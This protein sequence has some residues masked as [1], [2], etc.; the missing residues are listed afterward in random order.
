VLDVPLFEQQ[1]AVENRRAGCPSHRVVGQTVELEAAVGLLNAAR[2]DSHP[3]FA[4]AVEAGL[5]SIRLFVDVDELLGR[6][7]QIERRIRSQRIGGSLGC[8]GISGVRPDVFEVAVQ[9]R[10]PVTGG[11]DASVVPLHLR[12]VEGTQ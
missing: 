5:W 1:L 9:C 12:A 7:V 4:V 11:V 2:C 8:C 6:G 3:V 10:N